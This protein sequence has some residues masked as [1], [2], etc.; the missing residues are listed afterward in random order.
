MKFNWGSNS[1][2][3]NVNFY[4]EDKLDEIKQIQGDDVPDLSPK[5]YLYFYL[6][7]DDF[8]T[9]FFIETNKAVKDYCEKKGL[10][11]LKLMHDVD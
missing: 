9:D 7:K 3:K 2:L 4:N 6:P 1:P 11:G 8:D 10:E 5:E